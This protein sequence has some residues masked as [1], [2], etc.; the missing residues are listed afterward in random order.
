MATSFGVKKWAFAWYDFANSGYLIIFQS[1]LFP[2]FFADVLDKAGLNGGAWWGWMVALSVLAAMALG[3]IIGRLADRRNKSFIFIFLVLSAFIF[4]FISSLVFSERA[5]MLIVFFIIFNTCFE[6]SQTVYD[7]FL[8]DIAND[9]K[10]KNSVSALAYGFGYFGG[11]VMLTVYFLLEKLGADSQQILIV[12]SFIFLCFS[13]FPMIIFNRI[14]KNKLIVSLP[15][16]AKT[17]E[18]LGINFKTLLIYWI[19]ADVVTAVTFFAALFGERDL[20]L[21]KTA[22]GYLLILM[23]ILAFPLTVLGSKAANIFGTVRMIRVSLVFWLVGLVVAFLS[24]GI[25]HLVVSIVIFSFVFG[26]TQSLLRS[27]YANRIKSG[28]GEAFGYFALANKSASVISPA[29]VG[30][31]IAWTGNI[32]PAFILLAFLVLISIYLSKYLEDGYKKIY[33]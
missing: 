32:R 27:H 23:Q 21:S 11:V 16:K 10:K 19:I 13:V 18:R 15:P 33:C 4:T 29:L 1:F 6:L 28:A 26:T 12:S 5:W 24:Q 25:W 3:P 9:E 20:Q 22:I 8:P 31:I 14:E 2:L 30:L 17:F 7:S